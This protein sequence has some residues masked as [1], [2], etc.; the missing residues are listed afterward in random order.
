MPYLSRKITR[1]KWERRDGLANGEIPADAVT[2]DL[3]T[4]DNTLS[5]WTFEDASDEGIRATALVLATAADRV[6][7]MDIVWV[8]QDLLYENRLSIRKPSLP[9]YKQRPNARRELT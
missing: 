3:R 6:D 2:A 7:R 5:F 4:T 8:M 9:E 1:A